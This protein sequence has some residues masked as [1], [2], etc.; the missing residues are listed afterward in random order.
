MN[1]FLSVKIAT[2]L[3]FSVLLSAPNEVSAQSGKSS[4]DTAMYKRILLEA[5]AA[6]SDSAIKLYEEAIRSIGNCISKSDRKSKRTLQ[7]QLMK[8]YSG[9]GMVYFQDLRYDKARQNFDPAYNLSKELSSPVDMADCLFNLAELCLEQSQFREA[10]RYY[11]E[12]MDQYKI[13]GDASGQFWCYTGMGIVQKQMGNLGDAVVC[14]NKA[15]D[16]TQK[17]GL[18]NEAASCY[19][20]L[21]NVYRKKGDFSRAMESYE[22]AINQFKALKN[23]MMVSDCQNN[24]GNLYLDH[25]DPFRALD[26]YNQS[27]KIVKALN[28]EYRLIIRYKNIAD[29]YT[30]LKDYENAGQFLNDAMKLAQKSGDKSFLASCYMQLGKLQSLRKEPEIALAYYEK[31]LSLFETIGSKADVAEALVE[32][33]QI[34]LVRGNINESIKYAENAVKQ[35]AISGSL[36]IRLDAT[37][38]LSNG[39]E[40]KGDEKLALEWMKKAVR[41]KDSIYNADKYRTIEEIEAG[42]VQNS[43]TE[44]NKILTENSQLQKNAIRTRN[45]LVIL[46]ALCLILSAVI[47]WLVYKRQKEA[48]KETAKVQQLSEEKIGKLNEDLSV[49]ERELT[50][51]T[52]FINQKNQL[53]EKLIKDLE[54][55][56]QSG[57]AAAAIH[58]LQSTLKQEL[59]PNNWKEFELQFNDVHPGFQNRLLEQYPELSPSERRLCSFIRLDMNTREISSL[60]GQSIKSIEV[61]RTRIRKKLNVPHEHNLANFIAKL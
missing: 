33:A 44:E 23:D 36:K 28:D 32:I 35:S 1:H 24:I 19:N 8:S 39:Y 6:S 46:M 9:L 50:S 61:A 56:K 43:L 55:L 22:K 48:K 57:G 59:S 18:K 27:L 30:D 34:E 37:L 45:I 10:T 60:S 26:Y 58:G 51:K 31:A 40:Q 53:L 13:A 47:I 14:Y 25:G 11:T 7:K 41:L 20:N 3:L 54:E 4:C 38:C 29:A 21:G 42:F 12:S 2:V 17:A 16:V 5:S 49:K 52:I 15:L